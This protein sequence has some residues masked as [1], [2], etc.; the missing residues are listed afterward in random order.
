VGTS[1]RAVGLL[2]DS[3]FS[4]LRQMI[5]LGKG[6]CDFL[7]SFIPHLRIWAIVFFDRQGAPRPGLF[8]SCF[9]IFFFSFLIFF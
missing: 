9:F 4:T 7:F 5:V 2:D 8:L 6:L 1:S 3:F